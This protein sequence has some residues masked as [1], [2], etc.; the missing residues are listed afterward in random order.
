MPSPQAGIMPND[1]DE[2]INAMVEKM[3]KSIRIR[4]KEASI[5]IPVGKEDMDEKFLNENVQ[6]I[7]KQLES[8]LPKGKENIKDVLVKFTMSKPIK[9]VNN[10]K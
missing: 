7:L 6:E 1:K 4:N 8:K 5:K 10:K 9:F 3:K 2:T